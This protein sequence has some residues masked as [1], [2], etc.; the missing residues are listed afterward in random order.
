M[1]I[2]KIVTIEYTLQD[3]TYDEMVDFSEYLVQNK[4]ISNY[5]I[6]DDMST[7]VLMS[8]LDEVGSWTMYGNASID[9][10]VYDRVS[11]FIKGVELRKAEEDGA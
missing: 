10:E 9:K 11:Y 6:S 1:K 3:F 4:I 2:Q 8:E 5:E 7:I